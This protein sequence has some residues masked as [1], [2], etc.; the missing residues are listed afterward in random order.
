MVGLGFAGASMAAA[1]WLFAASQAVAGLSAVLCTVAVFAGVMVIRGRAEQQ[2]ARKNQSQASICDLGIETQRSDDDSA[3]PDG[4]TTPTR[5]PAEPFIVPEELTQRV[6]IA[7]RVAW[8]TM[9][10]DV[11]AKRAA[12]AELALRLCD[13]A[14]P[15]AKGSRSPGRNADGGLTLIRLERSDEG[16][17]IARIQPCDEDRPARASAAMGD[18]T[19]IG[20]SGFAVIG[21]ELRTPLNAIIGFSDLLREERASALPLERRH[22]YAQ[23]IHEAA[24]H[25]LDVVNSVLDVS[26]VGAGHY[27]I[28]R[29]K[30]DVGALIRGAIALVQLRADE[31]RIH[32]NVH[33]EQAR[34][35]AHGDQRAIKQV[36]LNLLSNAIKFTP[37]HGC[38]TV[39][40]VVEKDVLAITVSDTG[41][42]MSAADL[43]QI[44][45]P[46]HR[47][48]N[49]Y[50]RAAEGTG[51]GLSLTKGLITLHG[52]TMAID[53]A[54]QV[55][56]KVTV[57]IPPGVDDRQSRR[58]ED[59]DT[60][61]PMVVPMDL[62]RPVLDPQ[63]LEGVENAPRKFG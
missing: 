28:H 19:T 41:I 40:A 43:E 62:F 54:P 14:D 33:I 25:L 17:V 15:N 39:E 52:G 45:Q 22:D 44:G 61:A 24:T 3:L 2:A 38:V 50:T 7:D 57:T 12:H 36:L 59:L 27:A 30:F 49:A 60:N 8:L 10:A 42:G 51:L 5:I 13:A 47:I 21:H 1:I 37:D 16:T 32:L 34:A 6:H 55:G 20:R 58:N 31:K 63:G 46:F 11:R 18:G 23:T 56:T 35:P 53:S 9:L 29:E 4:L 26:K 48:D